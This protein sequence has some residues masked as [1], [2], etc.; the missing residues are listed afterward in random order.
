MKKINLLITLIV[1]I[2]FC[3]LTV[4]VVLSIHTDSKIDGEWKEV[5]L[6]LL[7]AFI[8]SYGKVIDFWF[9]SKEETKKEENDK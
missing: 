2:T 3:V 8:G 9:V 4:G 7:G 1:I 5:L 6:L